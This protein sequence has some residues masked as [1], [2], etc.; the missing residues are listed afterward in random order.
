[1][2]AR[3]RQLWIDGVERSCTHKALDDIRSEG[4]KVIAERCKAC[5]LVVAQYGVCAG[6]GRDRRCGF[7]VASRTRL[8]RF[9]S[10]DCYAAKVRAEK[11]ARQEHQAKKG[12]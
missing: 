11:E 10:Q 12:A 8:G 3:V 5:G 2:A 9:C 7:F 6:C 1:V 4:G